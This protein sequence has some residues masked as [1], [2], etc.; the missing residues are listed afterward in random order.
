MV[1]ATSGSNKTGGPFTQM[2]RW[3]FSEYG[4]SSCAAIV[5]RSAPIQRV[6][7]NNEWILATESDSAREGSFE[8]KSWFI[9]LRIAKNFSRVGLHNPQ[10]ESFGPGVG[11]STRRSSTPRR[12]RARHQASS[13]LEHTGSVLSLPAKVLALDAGPGAVRVHQNTCPSEYKIA[14]ASEFARVVCGP[15]PRHHFAAFNVSAKAVQCV[16]VALH[17]R[18]ARTE[19]EGNM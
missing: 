1:C 6:L 7:T 9:F 19:V 17:V 15:A 16:L 11:S 18:R 8:L 5:D 3:F 12:S 13:A 2:R 4:A 10:D 14:T